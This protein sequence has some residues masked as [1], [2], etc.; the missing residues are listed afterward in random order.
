MKLT[1]IDK[2]SSV[3]LFIDNVVIQ[4]LIVQGLGLLVGR[5]HEGQTV[6]KRVNFLEIRRK[7]ARE[8]EPPARV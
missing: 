6:K 2:K 8:A 4:D 5:R 7:T 1:D 3:F